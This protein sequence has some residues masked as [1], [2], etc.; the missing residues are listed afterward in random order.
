[1]GSPATASCLLSLVGRGLS[2]GYSLLEGRS[3]YTNSLSSLALQFRG[4]SIS[5]GDI[6]MADAFS[7]EKPNEI[8]IKIK[9]FFGN[10]N[11]SVSL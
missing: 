2:E 5:N 1:M 7:Q 11:F 10:A 3:I 4:S 8:N 6:Q 9:V